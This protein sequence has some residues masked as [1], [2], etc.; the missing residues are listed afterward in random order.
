MQNLEKTVDRVLDRLLLLPS[1]RDSAGNSGGD[2][3][4]SGKHKAAKNG[5]RSRRET[6]GGMR[7]KI[8]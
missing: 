2:A 6:G 8:Y 4:A 5:G 1:R 3:H 7:N